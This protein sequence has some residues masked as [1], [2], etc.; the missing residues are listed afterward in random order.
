MSSRH[1]LLLLCCFVIVGVASYGLLNY[2]SD[3]SRLLYPSTFS[4]HPTGCKALFLLLKELN[5]PAARWRSRYTRLESVNGVL[6]VLDPQSVPFTKRE[7]K[8][9][10]KWIRQ[11]NTLM[12]FHGGPRTSPP[13]GAVSGRLAKPEG[14]KH[15]ETKNNQETDEDSLVDAFDLVPVHRNKSGRSTV[16]VSEQAIYGVSG[17]S[18]SNRTRW[19]SAT[20]GWTVVVRDKE[21]PVIVS[22]KMGKGEVIAVSDASMASNRILPLDQNVR[23]VPALL[24]QK[25]KPGKVLF[26]EYHHGHAMAESFWHYAASSVFGW[27]LLQILVAGALVLYSRRASHAGRFRSLIQP[28]GR[29][30]L[31]YVQSMA[32]VLES[33]KAGTVALDAVMRRF[34]TH[35]SRKTG[36]PLKNLEKDPDGWIGSLV[37]SSGDP[38]G[39]FRECREA[40]RSG[41][42]TPRTFDLARRLGEIRVKLR[43]DSRIAIAY[44]QR[45]NDAGS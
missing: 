3:D 22:A 1:K 5:L 10:K 19:K 37:G 42:E 18:V 28:K 8:S 4:T 23:L 29:S 31:E 13:W 21:G 12:M 38:G 17:L 35:L 25:G 43:H 34:L 45:R 39:L 44:S 14:K 7:I 30:S 16:N 26:D 36:I 27:I 24:L 32:N 9:L 15:G 6:I 33:S 20:G 41:K 40:I 11:G 2:V